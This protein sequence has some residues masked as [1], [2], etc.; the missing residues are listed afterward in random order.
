MQLENCDLL[1]CVE[2]GLDSLGSSVKTVI[3]SRMYTRHNAEKSEVVSDPTVLT[4]VIQEMFHGSTPV[5]EKSI[6]REIK[7]GFNLPLNETDGLVAAISAAKR[8]MIQ[9]P[10][11]A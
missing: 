7:K 2:K 5:I 4:R 11:I 10:H 8:Q 6:I 3:F 1:R 9:A